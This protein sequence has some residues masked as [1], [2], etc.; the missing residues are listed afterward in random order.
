MICNKCNQEKILSN[1]KK[2]KNC[3]KIYDH[4]YGIKNRKKRT[5]YHDK[6]VQNNEKHIEKYR[7][8]YFTNNKCRI[9]K[10][11]NERNKKNKNQ[12]NKKRKEY[13]EKNKEKI[14]TARKIYIAN[15]KQ[16]YRVM[17]NKWKKNKRK[18]DPCFRLRLNCSGMILH[19]L[20]GNKK[21]FSILKFLPYSMNELKIHLEFQFDEFM[22]WD[23][24]GKYWEID[25]IVPQSYFRFTSMSDLEFQECW[26]LINLRPLECSKNRSKNN[27]IDIELIESKKIILS[28]KPNRHKND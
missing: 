17:C 10:L 19:A 26:Q 8:K 22:S 27:K 15:N 24:Y 23:N 5:D 21:N 14:K 11:R 3:K 25:H 4:E 1:K 9:N 12:V 13:R 2:K 7:K 18:S 28:R 6:W 20:K 16:N